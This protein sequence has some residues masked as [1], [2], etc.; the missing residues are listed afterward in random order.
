MKKI[1][2]REGL[3][4]LSFGQQQ[5]LV[6]LIAKEGRMVKLQEDKATGAKVVELEKKH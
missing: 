4:N 5:W 3:T 1:I 2:K 6:G